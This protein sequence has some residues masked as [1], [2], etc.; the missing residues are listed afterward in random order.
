MKPSEFTF[1]SIES[2]FGSESYHTLCDMINDMDL[3][4]TGVTA[5]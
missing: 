4:V 3:V 5:E 2:I 1:A